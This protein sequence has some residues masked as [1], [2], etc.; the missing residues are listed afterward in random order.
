MIPGLHEPPSFPKEPPPARHKKKSKKAKVHDAHPQPPVD[1]GV[2]DHKAIHKAAHLWAKSD[3]NDVDFSTL[4]DQELKE[5]NLHSNN[6]LAVLNRLVIAAW[7]LLS[8]KEQQPWIDEANEILS[9]EPP[10]V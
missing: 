5:K 4:A 3:S 7:D 6:R 10:L 9:A 2:T 8:D 1:Y